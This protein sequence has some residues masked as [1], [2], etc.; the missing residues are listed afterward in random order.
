MP[1]E[2]RLVS[3]SGIDIGGFSLHTKFL[4]DV[5]KHHPH[6]VAFISLPFSDKLI[7]S[8]VRSLNQSKNDILNNQELRRKLEPLHK[9]LGMDD[10]MSD[11]K[12]LK[13]RSKGKFHGSKL[14]KNSQVYA[15]VI[16][17]DAEIVIKV[18][19]D[20]GNGENDIIGRRTY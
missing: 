11:V 19:Y 9:M 2:I 8:F 16:N 7:L 10:V 12:T 15:E 5:L 17:Q 6:N 13:K 4:N 14:I 18:E 20:E 1:C 3:S